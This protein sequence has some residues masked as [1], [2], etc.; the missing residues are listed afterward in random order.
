ML[1]YRAS[2]VIWLISHVLDP[3]VYLA[4]WSA[5]SVGAGGS[6]GGYGAADFA[7]YFIVLM[8][9]N[10]VTYTWIMFEYEYRVRHGS[11][12]LTL[13]RPVHPIHADVAD[14]V[15]SKL[16]TLPL[17]AAAA[18]ILA[19]IFRPAFSIPGWAAAVYVPA[20]LLAFGVRFLMEWT[21]ALAAFWTTRVGAVNQLYFIASLF[22]SGQMAPLSLL[23]RPLQIA[24]SIL[25]FRW[26]TSF[27]VE[28]L[29]GRVGFTDALYGLAAQ[30][31]WLGLCFLLLRLAWRAGLR[32]YTAV[33][34]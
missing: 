32:V 9:T 34:A 28:L 29:L 14:N 24:A 19:L 25:P 15:S 8:L 23:P 12:S 3:V 27:P 17:I 18:V 20:L 1:Q 33:G 13:L 26:T 11:L 21:L 31:A 10:H 30:A 16:I 6:V 7:A 2:L 5:V 22:L 4:V